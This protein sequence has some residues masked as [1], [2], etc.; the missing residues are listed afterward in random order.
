MT[1]PSPN[2]IMFAVNELDGDRRARPTGEQERRNTDL[3]V[4]SVGYRSAPLLGND[5]DE[6]LDPALGK[7]RNRQGRVHGADGSLVRNVYTCGW[8]SNGAKGVLGTTMYDAY[9]VADLMI[10]DHL[11]Q[12]VDEEG[13]G[14]TRLMNPATAPGLPDM[15]RS[16]NLAQRVFSYDDWRKIDLE[17][18]RRGKVADKERERMGWKEVIEFV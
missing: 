5:S 14:A 3:I 17:E 16:S 11:S 15:L 13:P 12:S 9:D 10:S 7:I 18:I 1:T 8:A 6:W 4:T 2:E